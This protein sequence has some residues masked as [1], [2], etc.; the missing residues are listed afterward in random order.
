LGENG[1]MSNMPSTAPPQAPA[2]PEPGDCCGGGCARCVFDVHD[3]ALERHR[4]ALSAWAS[5]QQS[6][7]DEGGDKVP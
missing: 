5:R 3:E 2:A 6:A 4:L 7:G 1:R